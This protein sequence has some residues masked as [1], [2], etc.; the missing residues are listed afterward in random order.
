LSSAE[1][2]LGAAERVDFDQRRKRKQVGVRGTAMKRKRTARVRANQMNLHQPC[3]TTK[4]P[5]K[6]RIDN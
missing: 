3:S 2:G 5:E 1:L 4:V 6:R